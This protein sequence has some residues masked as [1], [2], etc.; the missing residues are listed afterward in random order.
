MRKILAALAG[1]AL[2]G[3]AAALLTRPATGDAGCL[4]DEYLSNGQM[5]IEAVFESLPDTVDIEV[6]K[7]NALEHNPAKGGTFLGAR[8]VRLSDSA[9][10][11]GQG[12]VYLIATSVDEPQPIHGANITGTARCRVA[13]VDAASGQWLHNFMFVVPDG[14]PAAFP[15]LSL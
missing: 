5:R 4:T 13:V 10:K 14:T 7:A 15:S 2:L 6:A 1:V 11:G 8:L 3:V 12:N 9:L